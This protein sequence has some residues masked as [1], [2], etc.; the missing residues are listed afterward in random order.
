MD[1]YQ[2]LLLTALISILIAFLIGK[3]AAVGEESDDVDRTEVA[4]DLKLRP[5]KEEEGEEERG[6]SGGIEVKE[7]RSREEK[8]SGVDE[9]GVGEVLM[10]ETSEEVEIE[11]ID[12]E[13]EEEEE[14]VEEGGS[15]LHGEDEWEGIERSEVEEL[16]DVAVKYVGSEGGAAAVAKLSNELQMQLYG[17]HK[18]ATEGP[19]Y[20]PH[21]MALKLSTRA[22]WHA[23]QRL[24][25]ISPE[26]AMEQYVALLSQ[27]IPGWMIEKSKAE[28]KQSDGD[29][30]PLTEVSQRETSDSSLL[31][32]HPSTV[33]RL[34]ED[35]SHTDVNDET[36]GQKL[37]KEGVTKTFLFNLL[38]PARMTFL[39]FFL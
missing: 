28:L 31:L 6:D 37:S 34:S 16:F 8:E 38:S 26:V 21:P 32:H 22:K 2:E 19:C 12:E 14:V 5:I 4:A 10:K 20:D 24:G 35:T 18:A 30:S 23:W 33:E 11:R 25:N 27:N 13:E 29:D 17:L 9:A 3:I 1:F 7:G 39:T 36:T 15:L